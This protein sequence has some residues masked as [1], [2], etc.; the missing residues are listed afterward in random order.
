M[1][2]K[3]TTANPLRSRKGCLVIGKSESP[4]GAETFGALDSAGEGEL[5]RILRKSGFRPEI[6][7]SLHIHSSIGSDADSVLVVGCG[8]EGL[9]P[10]D[11]R[12]L[13][14]AAARALVEAKVQNV[15]WC[16]SEID[17]DGQDAAAGACTAVEE[18]HNADYRYEHTLAKTRRNHLALKRIDI[19]IPSGAKRG[20]IDRG[21]AGGQAIAA[22]RSL[23][24]DL[25][26]LPGNICTPE[27][28]AGTARDIAKRHS[29]VR[30][31]I[32]DEARIERLKMNTFLAVARGSREAPRFVIL[33]YR[34]A[35][36]SRAP[37]VL[38]GKGITFDSGGISIKPAGAMDEMKFD[39]C[40]AASERLK[41]L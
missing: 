24:R 34:G 10:A 1:E 30:A 5:E 28:L 11:F 39:M 9:S 3:S 17:V 41:T 25:G 12:K 31:R 37:I 19:H 36:A 21:I 6:G 40:G 23:A 38:I 15:I 4:S 16:L 22:G 7:K 8:G 29:R 33:E 13:C 14:A 2:I 18:L 27:Y 35:E 26:N 20:E 32:L